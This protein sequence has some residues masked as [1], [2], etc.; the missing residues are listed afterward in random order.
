MLG[1]MKCEKI[2]V[3]EESDDPSSVHGAGRRRRLHRKISDNLAEMR[4]EYGGNQR[5]ISD[6]RGNANWDIYG[7]ERC[8]GAG[9]RCDRGNR[10]R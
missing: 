10:W 7:D 3:S 1:G 6:S 5:G 8:D 2:L 9:N 4:S